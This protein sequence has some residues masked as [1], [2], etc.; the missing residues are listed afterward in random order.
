MPPLHYVIFESSLMIFA[1]ATQFDA[2]SVTVK[3]SPKVRCDLSKGHLVAGPHAPPLHLVLGVVLQ[4]PVKGG[5]GPAAK[6]RGPGG[7]EEAGGAGH[8][9]QSLADDLAAKTDPD[10]L[11][12]PAAA[13]ARDRLDVDGVD[14]HLAR[15]G[16]E[17][18]LVA[19]YNSTFKEMQTGG[20]ALVII[21]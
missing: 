12:V 5:H 20:T 6:V 11:L 13:L 19:S 15:P 17:R 1:L 21:V 16:P 4:P 8:A 7:V 2:F 18:S 3:T 14:Q 9:G 10:P